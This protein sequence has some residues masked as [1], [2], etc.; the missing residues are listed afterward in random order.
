M[1]IVD[2]PVSPLLSGGGSDPC[3]VA[4][5]E[6]KFLDVTVFFVRSQIVTG[7]LPSQLKHFAL[8]WQFAEI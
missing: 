2:A 8:D 1:C 6:T 3:G 7:C 5:S 4:P